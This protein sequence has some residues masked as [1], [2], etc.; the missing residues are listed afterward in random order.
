MRQWHVV[1]LTICFAITT[2]LGCK[3]CNPSKPEGTAPEEQDESSPADQQRP[4]A[5]KNASSAGRESSSDSDEGEANSPADASEA[6]SASGGGES[7]GGESA[8]KNST[9]RR[10]SGQT[11]GSASGGPPPRLAPPKFKTPDS[12]LRFASQQRSTAA[13]RANKQKY[14]S[15]YTELLKGWQALQPHLSDSRC[16]QLSAELLVEMEVYGEQ[17]STNGQPSIGKPLKIK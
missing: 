4:V 6:S 10:G 14:D 17:F 8:G 16:R 9:S 11:S 2:S 5:D 15:A 1:L 7:G 13:A 3:G 12:G